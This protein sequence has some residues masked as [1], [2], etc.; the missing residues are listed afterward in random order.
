MDFTGQIILVTGAS[1]GIGRSIAH[2]FAEK[3]GRVAV[4]YNSKA[5]A[6]AET[7]ASLAG[8]GHLVVQADLAD[9][10]A[11]GCMVET[12][13]SQMGGLNVLVNNAAIYEDHA[14]AKVD[15]AA[16][17]SSWL[18][19]IQAN[20]LGAANATYCAAQHMIQHGGGR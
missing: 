16:W 10:A 17:Q 3:G 5:Q 2:Q 1:R 11:V 19:T 4:H 20:L 7:L 9:A 13:I 15:Y 8:S 14:I 6:A 18:Q 12:V